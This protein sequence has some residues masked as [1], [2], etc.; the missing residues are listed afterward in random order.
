MERQPAGRIGSVQLVGLS[1]DEALNWSIVSYLLM[2]GI[3]CEMAIFRISGIMWQFV[4]LLATY[5]FDSSTK[6]WIWTTNMLSLEK[7]QYQKSIKSFYIYTGNRSRA[8]GHLVAG[9]MLFIQCF[10]N[11]GGVHVPR[12]A[13]QASAVGF[14]RFGLECL[15]IQDC[16]NACLYGLNQPQWSQRHPW[17]FGILRRK[18]YTKHSH[19]CGSHRG[20]AIPCYTWSVGPRVFADG[21]RD[22]E[23]KQ[24]CSWVS[25]F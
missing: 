18:R 21:F 2:K 15:K 8:S 25:L 17:L 23:M 6:M 4:L 10:T 13:Q 16:C 14:G 20:K 9:S 12:T 11:H 3:D 22:T 19:S 5:N 7:L 24:T 1:I